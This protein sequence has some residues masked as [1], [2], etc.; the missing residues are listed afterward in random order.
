M[1]L[2]MNKM[3]VAIIAAVVIVL[4]LG[5]VFLG[6]AGNGHT[7]TSATENEAVVYKETSHQA[8][9]H[10]ATEHKTED[11]G[12]AEVESKAKTTDETTNKNAQSRNAGYPAA[13]D[14]TLK[15]LGNE[16]VKLSDFK[17]KVV[18]INFWAT[19]CPPCRAEI[20]YFVD[21]YKKYE[22]QGFV[23]LGIAVDPREFGKV[24]GF[25]KQNDI[26]Y[27]ILLD[28]AGVSNLYGGIESIPT[29]FVVNRDGR[30]VEMIIGS[31]P[32]EVFESVIQSL[33]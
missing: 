20:P 27:P 19:W 16:D 6:N 29:T 8:E 10:E 33:L 26:S 12:T 15:N 11:Q 1:T 21:L 28:Q 32:K 22:S 30:I 24:S 31:R 2:P 3:V 18:F 7:E 5:Y 14:F 25:V 13:P 23:V 9:T 4:A 17:G